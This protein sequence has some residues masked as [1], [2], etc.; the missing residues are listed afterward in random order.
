MR[1]LRRERELC[2]AVFLLC[3][4]STGCLVRHR[5]VVPQGQRVPKPL[6]TA[7]KAQLIQKLHD[8]FDPVH[9]FQMKTDMSPSV[10]GLYGG[11]VTDYP[12]ISGFI[13]FLRPDSI[14]VVG[15]DPVIHTVAF[16]MVSIGNQF[17]VSIPAKS[18][19]IEGLND[20]PATSNNKLENLRPAAF[21]TA[22]MIDP[23]DPKKDIT[24]VEDDTDEQK[25]LYILMMIRRDGDLYYPSRSVY[26]DRY[27]L[28]L[29]Q[30]KTFDRNGDI[31]SE[32]KYSNWVDHNGVQFPSLIDIRRP[33]DGYEVVLTVTGLQLNP[34]DIVPPKFILNEPAGYH[35]K[36]LQ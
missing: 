12:T 4:C 21:L 25:A 1:L 8:L 11:T 34:P 23:P 7:S 17:R 5:V 16:D 36:Q 13:L 9:S 10:G 27:T 18:L 15:L 22:L 29:A 30:Q 33:K 6:L 3:V 35:L 14:R 24:L 26:F 2:A 31:L 28:R 19:F 20:A 32:T